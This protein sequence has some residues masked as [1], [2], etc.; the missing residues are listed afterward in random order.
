[1]RTRYSQA[2]LYEICR[3]YPYLITRV[4][5]LA[6]SYSYNSRYRRPLLKK[7]YRTVVDSFSACHERFLGQ[8]CQLTKGVDNLR[9]DTKLEVRQ[10]DR[11]IDPVV[12]PFFP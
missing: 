9:N 2:V 1:M 3:R 12:P 11:C 5:E 10:G 7:L 8:D 4:H 6:Y